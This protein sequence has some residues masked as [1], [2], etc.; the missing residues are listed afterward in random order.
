LRRSQ[1]GFH[2]SE[3]QSLPGASALNDQS[4]EKQEKHFS[5]FPKERIYIQRADGFIPFLVRHET[6]SVGA[7]QS[8]SIYNFTIC[9]QRFCLQI[10]WPVIWPEFKTLSLHLLELQSQSL[11][12]LSRINSPAA[13]THAQQHFLCA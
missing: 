6:F 9:A 1:R 10:L 5:F 12:W 2:S 3:A 13:V 11:C 7:A 8:F 4:P